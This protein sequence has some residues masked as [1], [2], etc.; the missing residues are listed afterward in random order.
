MSSSTVQRPSGRVTAGPERRGALRGVAVPAEHGGWALTL[1]PALL[2]LLI[3]A[4][5]AGWCLAAA[6]LLA[7]VAR[8][9]LKVVLVDHWR[10]RSLDRTVVAAWVATI[11]LLVLGVLAI[12]AAVLASAPFWWPLLAAAPLIGVELWFDMRSRSRRLV[13]ELAGAIGVCAVVAMIVLADGVESRVALGL[14][15]LLASRVITS[16]PFVRAQIAI[17]RQRPVAT[18]GL[19]TADASALLVAAVAVGLEPSLIVGAIAIG[20]LVV[21][22]RVTARRPVPRVSVIGIRQMVAGVVVIAA[23]AIGVH[24]L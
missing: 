17:A 9:P 18:G 6:A 24:V 12:T 21:F 2:G 8:T 22:Q 15:F 20:A 16:I 3:A 10:K 23:T 11:E 7:F 13:P 14:W 1:E 19:V 5:K 4:S